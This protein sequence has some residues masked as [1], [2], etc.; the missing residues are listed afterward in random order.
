M[1][2]IMTQ[3]RHP[4]RAHLVVQYAVE[5]VIKSR[6]SLLEHQSADLS[7]I[8]L[9]INGQCEPYKNHHVFSLNNV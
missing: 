6:V 2:Y 3:A 8:L 5:A 1:A 4:L 7:S 9:A